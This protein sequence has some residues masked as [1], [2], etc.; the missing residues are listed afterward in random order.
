M[1]DSQYHQIRINPA[2]GT[3]IRPLVITSIIWEH[4]NLNP[5]ETKSYPAVWGEREPMIWYRCDI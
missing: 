1:E 4:E 2:A 3:Y 5:A